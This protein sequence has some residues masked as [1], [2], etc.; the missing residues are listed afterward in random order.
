M[1][2]Q[3]FFLLATIFAFSMVQSQIVPNLRSGGS[4]Q[5]NHIVPNLRAG[6]SLWTGKQDISSIISSLTSLLKPKQ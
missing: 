2:F 3:L 5:S 6:G 1:N 4:E